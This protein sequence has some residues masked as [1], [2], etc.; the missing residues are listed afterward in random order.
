MWTEAGLNWA[1]GA[2]DPEVT[3][4]VGQIEAELGGRLPEGYTSEYLPQLKAWLLSLIHI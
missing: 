1:E 4:A 2:E 3:A